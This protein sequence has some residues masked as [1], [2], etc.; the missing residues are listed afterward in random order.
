MS[1]KRLI[2]GQRSP[3]IPAGTINGMMD[4]VDRLAAQVGLPPGVA[5][6][7]SVD[8]STAL[9]CLAKNTSGATLVERAPAGV[10][11]SAFELPDLDPEAVGG[12]VA[13]QVILNAPAIELEAP[14]AETKNWVITLGPIK[15]NETGLVVI[16]GLVAVRV[17][18]TDA[19]H[20]F[21]TVQTGDTKYLKSDASGA[22][23][24]DRKK[25]DVAEAPGAIPPTTP[26]GKQWAL[27]LIGGGGGTE[28]FGNLAIVTEVATEN[29][30]VGTAV[31]LDTSLRPIT[32]VNPGDP[33]YDLAALNAAKFTF[34][35]AHQYCGCPVGE[36]IQWF[37]VKGIEHTMF[38]DFST[39]V[40]FGELTDAVVELQQRTGGSD[41]TK[42][43]VGGATPDDLVFKGKQCP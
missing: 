10:K 31:P 15:N 21:A 20:K 7:A 36:R 1:R 26:K 5:Q 41:F 34:T 2:V 17:D 13:T 29:G 25:L 24:W 19:T 14:T 30:G 3:H 16:L 32:P 9:V 33:G 4:D 6:F 27:V 42:A 11:R 40:V 39:E 8:G 22:A 23:I 35:C 28:V 18:V 37:T 12:D 43:L 38:G